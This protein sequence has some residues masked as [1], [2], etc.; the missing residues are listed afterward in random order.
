MFTLE[1]ILNPMI[2]QSNSKGQLYE[3][4]AFK[5]LSH[6]PENNY[7]HKNSSYNRNLIIN[8]ANSSGAP[9]FVGPTNPKGSIAWELQALPGNAQWHQ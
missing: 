6:T 3:S 2:I 9:T 5:K 8:V 4:R 7:D 1:M